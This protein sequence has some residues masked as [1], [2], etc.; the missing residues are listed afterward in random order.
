ML[1]RLPKTFWTTQEQSGSVLSVSALL[2]VPRRAALLK[3][4]SKQTNLETRG[5]CILRT[6]WFV[7]HV[8]LKFITIA[9]HVDF[10]L[11]YLLGYLLKISLV[12]G[13]YK[14]RF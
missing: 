5:L 4:G 2:N 1:T 14:P 7:Y 11:M 6:G 3:F 10:V 12:I 13:M 8:Q 9:M